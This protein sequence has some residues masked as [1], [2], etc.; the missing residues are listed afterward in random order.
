MTPEAFQTTDRHL[1]Q[2][3]WPYPIH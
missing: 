2:T 3:C 1:L